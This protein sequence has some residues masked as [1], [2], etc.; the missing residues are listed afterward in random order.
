M[1]NWK[2]IGLF[3]LVLVISGLIF[4]CSEKGSGK[5]T[6][7][8][9]VEYWFGKDHYTIT[10][11]K[12]KVEGL[13]AAVK[14]FTGQE[15]W[16]NALQEAHLSLI[17]ARRDLESALN[18]RDLNVEIKGPATDLIVMIIGQDGSAVLTEEIEKKEMMDNIEVK[19]FDITNPYNIKKPGVYSLVVKTFEPEKVIYKA[20]IKLPSADQLITK[21]NTRAN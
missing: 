4:G 8:Y 17:L 18:N 20:A 19:V 1:K 5:T 14:R 11:T 16:E 15:G 9:Q 12:Q 2:R 3:F 6:E 13:E 10:R 7:G 21:A